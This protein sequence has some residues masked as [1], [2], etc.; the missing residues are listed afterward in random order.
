MKKIYL[1]VLLVFAF[2]FGRAQDYRDMIADGSYTVQEIQQ[3]AK[4]YFTNSGKGRGTGF[5][6][7]KRWEYQALRAM[8][9]NGLLK[10]P[11][12]YYNELQRYNSY[13]N[14]NYG[15]AARNTTGTWQE[16]GP[17][18]W[19]QTSGWN[20][21]VGRITAM[22]IDPD[23]M[24]HIIVGA[25]TGGVW[26]TLDGGA[27]WTVLTDD[28]STLNVFALTMEPGNAN[29]YYWGSSSGV[30]FKSTNAGATWDFLADTGNGIVNK[31]LIDPNNVSKMYCSVQSGGLYKSTNAGANWTRIAG[32]A[33]QGYDVEFKPGNTGVIY[34]S[35]NNFYRSEDGGA[36]FL[37]SSIITTSGPKM[38]GVSNDNPE[39]VY[40]IEAQNGLFNA[41]YKSTS[42]GLLFT[43]LNH[44]TKNYF[45]YSSAADDD[46]GQA[47]RDMDI[48]VNP[49]DV[50][51]VHIA[52]INTWRSTNGGVSFGI[53]SQWVP[54]SATAANIGYCH[55][56]VDIMEYLNGVLFV[57]TDG[58]VFKAENPQVVSS[59]YYTDLTTGLG[60]R[61]FY[62]IG[63]SQTNPAIITG[64]SQD[65][66]TSVFDTNGN[67][68]DWLGADGMEGFVDKNDPTLLYGTSQFG[69]LYRGTNTGN[70][71]FNVTSPDGKGG[72][73]DWNWITPFEQDPIVPNTMYV[74]Y[75]ELYKSEDG[76]E[77]WTSIS[78]NYG[79]PIDHLKIASSDNN[80]MYMAVNNSFHASINGGI[81]WFQSPTIFSTNINAIAVHPTNPQKIALAVNDA[82][83]VYVSTNAGLTWTP[84]RLDLPNFP[85]QDLAWDNNDEQGLY[86]G[87]NYGVYYHDTTTNNSWLPY[88]NNLPNVIVSELEINFTEK[89]LYAGTYGRG[90]WVS[91][92][93]SS[94]LSTNEVVFENLQ[95]YP[96]TAKNEVFLSWN[97]PESV[98]VRI[99]NTEGK[100]IYHAKSINLGQPYNIDISQ[101][102]SG[103]YF[104]RINNASGEVTKK[105]VK[106]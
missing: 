96:N 2:V 8:D 91:D 19:N 55:A 51:E 14:Q 6:A 63:V 86:V 56:D 57:G 17:T 58:G 26:K 28:L 50:N 101:F 1:F 41:L 36:T 12:F 70:N 52:G 64:G 32:N 40:V 22:A 83:K 68:N 59:N 45:G 87:M 84:M 39:V 95:L 102:S 10:S 49:N 18:Y 29:V 66:G 69:V 75:D 93:Y 16:L 97:K 11:N 20:P 60:I 43:T 54:Q 4:N 78:S 53:T 24:D 27:S 90:L 13:V 25:E 99:F 15:F 72:T 62:K 105:L 37:Q 21:G 85:P 100:I 104:V 38:I 35:G 88:S 94:T 34:A 98:D 33:T 7:Y 9:E 89:K 31:I 74:A 80:Y 48:V 67:W 30:I 82:Q 71:A 92:L 81:N 106:Q 23:N 77:I 61:Q 44:D 3:A 73:A 103:M 65:N 46:L 76:G 47:P 42:S 5:K 79:T